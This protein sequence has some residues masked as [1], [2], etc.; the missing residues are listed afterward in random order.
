MSSYK[1]ELI[2]S[3]IEVVDSK[4]STLVGIKGKVTDETKNTLTI[5]N[6]K[7]LKSHITFKINGKIIQGKEIKKR[8]EDRIRK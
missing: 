8:P 7:I 2:G 1:S 6:K 3:N 5:G 4:N